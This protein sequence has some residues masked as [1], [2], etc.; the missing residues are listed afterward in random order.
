MRR[1]NKCISQVAVYLHEKPQRS[2][3]FGAHFRPI[4]EKKSALQGGGLS[5]N[6]RC[7]KIITVRL[8]DKLISSDDNNLMFKIS[9]THL[10]HPPISEVCQ[11]D[12]RSIAL[13]WHLMVVYLILQFLENTWR[14][15][16]SAACLT[17]Q[18]NGPS[19]GICAFGERN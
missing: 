7:L 3:V 5:K 18:V 11:S 9:K 6:L 2:T 16:W 10:E 19:G 1:E 15:H 14:D 12:C 4:R 13:I 17:K 8:P